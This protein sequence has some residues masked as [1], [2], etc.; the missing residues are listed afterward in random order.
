VELIEPILKS[1]GYAP[2]PLSD[3]CNL[4]SPFHDA[5]SDRPFVAAQIGQ[6]L[7]GRIATVSG[8][9]RDI[10]GEAALDHLHRMR[11]NV[12]AVIIGTGTVLADDPQLTVRRIIGNS[13]ARVVIDP[14]G[15][16]GTAAGKWAAE[17][18]VRR[19][20]ISAVPA[21][22][23]PGVEPIQLAAMDG[24]IAPKAIVEALFARGLRR[25][26]I[27]GGPRT[28]ALFIE[29]GCIDRLHV[30]ITPVIIGSGRPGFELSPVPELKAARRPRTKVYH[31]GGGDVLFDCDLS[32]CP[33]QSN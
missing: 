5:P 6:S 14:S 1:E 31:L 19:I 16:F 18:G 26:L 15:R 33:R 28:L 27:E 22:V 20:L 25:L 24:R 2:S 9:S 30:L 4:F 3:A 11:A 21:R 23:L 29:A 13:P 17:D 7:D 32:T 12:D 10:S 8:Q